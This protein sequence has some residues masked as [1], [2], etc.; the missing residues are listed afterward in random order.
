M[1]I[2]IAMDSF[3]EACSALEACEAV[4]KG[5]K[6][7]YPDAAIELVPMADGGEGT[8]QALVE[9]TNGTYVEVKVQGPL[10]QSVQA[11]YGLLGN[12]TTAVIEMAEA[13]GLH[14][15][16][17]KERNPLLTSTYGTGQ[18]IVDG[19]NR[20]I[21][22]FIIAI[23]GSATVDGG[24]GMARALGYRFLDEQDQEIPQ[25]G[26]GLSQLA[27]IDTT[28]VHS[29]LKEARIKVACDVTNIL[30][31]PQ[32]SA[33]V[34]G[35]QKGATHEM[36]DLL[37]ANLNHLDQ[38]IQ[39]DLGLQVGQ[40]PG[41]GAA[42]GLG[43][44]LLAFTPSSL[45]PGIEIVIQAT[46][47]KEKMSVVDL[48]FTGEGQMDFQTKFG[49][50]PYGVMKLAKQV[51]PMCKVIGLS[52][53]IGH[54]V[55]ELYDLGFDCILSIAPGAHSLEELIADTQTNLTYSARSISQL[56]K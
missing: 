33:A 7:V 2:I 35:P 25:G 50:T 24:T 48:C 56:V 44:G 55:E 12:G 1:K 27:K 5:V 40:I 34:F 30:C 4:A 42:G 10:G 13:S 29:A 14:L 15:V 46:G 8:V 16:P 45:E 36:V 19:L 20:G 38:I 43:A 39:R 37:D 21:R 49:K 53:S 3:K 47:L 22:D 17:L 26:G 23:G 6:E 51:S 54:K 41:S 52:G 9:A 31:G 18:L 28:N 32:G 11:K